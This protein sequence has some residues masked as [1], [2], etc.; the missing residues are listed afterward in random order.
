MARTVSRPDQLR[1]EVSPPGDKSISH[2]A[3]MFNA[4]ADG[5]ATVTNFPDGAD[6][7]STLRVLRAL[8]VRIERVDG[9]DGRGDTLTVH[10]AG[11]DGLQ[12]PAE[13]LDAGNS[14]TTMRL[15]SGLLAARPFLAILTGD[16]SLRGR[17][18]DRI[19]GPLR[20]MGALVSARDNGRLAPLVFHGGELNGIEYELPV[21]SAQLKSCL[22]L[23]GLRAKG[24]T[25]L[26]Q[27][28]ASRDHTER[29]LA[30]MGAEV[31]TE[32]LTV[33]VEASRLSAADVD[34]PGDLSSAAFWMVAGIT[35]PDADIRILNVGVNPTRAGILTLLRQMGADISLEN[36]RQVAG[37]PVADV[38]ARTSALRGVEVDPALIPLLIDELPVLAVAAA[39]AEGKTVISEAGELRVKETDRIAATSTWL[40]AADVQHEEAEDGLTI[41]GAGRIP[42]FRADSFGDHRIAMALA[43]AGLVCEGAVSLGRDEAADISYPGFWRHAEQLSGQALQKA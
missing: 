39:A 32:G 18:M 37:E 16:E 24:T 1:G 30:G 9:P 15:L 34:I 13:L 36:E 8:G 29:M 41:H 19:V 3:A 23:A 35:H 4:V 25:T 38:R 28:A 20:R 22:L 12:E 40:K 5:A 27:P 14:G 26:H 10:G 31:S 33:S 17:P 7:A 43:V 2:R 6:C 11:M 42:S 21:A